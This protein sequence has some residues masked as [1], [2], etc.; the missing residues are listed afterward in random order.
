MLL[1]RVGTGW[2]AGMLDETTLVAELLRQTLDFEPKTLDLS[3]RGAKVDQPQS[4]FGHGDGEVERGSCTNLMA[5]GSVRTSLLL[6]PSLLRTGEADVIEVAFVVCRWCILV[7]LTRKRRGD[8]IRRLS[9]NPPIL[10][11]D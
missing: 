2:L 3:E 10:T 7:V 1:Q 11:G 9:N 4:S 8:R 5:W 6:L